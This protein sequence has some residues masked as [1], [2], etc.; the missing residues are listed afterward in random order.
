M[1]EPAQKCENNDIFKQN[2]A[3]V[4]LIYLKMAIFCCFGLR[5]NLDFPDFLQLKFYNINYR[6]GTFFYLHYQCNQRLDCGTFRRCGW[7]LLTKKEGKIFMSFES[8]L[9][10]RILNWEN[11]IAAKC[12]I[13]HS[14]FSQS[15]KFWSFDLDDFL[16]LSSFF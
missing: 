1:P 14:T 10:G 8:I 16:V 13:T 11:L 2:N 7:Y 15:F 6:W 12:D 3:L 5:G 4:L 9:I